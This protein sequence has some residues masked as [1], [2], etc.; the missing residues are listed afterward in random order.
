MKPLCIMVAVLGA[1][2]CA[3]ASAALGGDV[4]S[5]AADRAHLRGALRTVPTVNYTVHEISSPGLVLREYATLDGRV[6][7]LSWHGQG[8]PDFRTVLGAY[9]A[10]YTRATA[11]PSRNHH[12]LAIDTPQLVLQSAGRTRGYTGRAWAPQLVPANFALSDLQ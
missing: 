5:V 11:T 7:A 2:C 6:F 1:G 9:Y 8:V 3:S 10:E 12:Q 4:G